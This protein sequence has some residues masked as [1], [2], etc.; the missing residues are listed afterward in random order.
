MEAMEQPEPASLAAGPTS[1][2]WPFDRVRDGQSA[3]LADARRTIAEGSHLLAHAPT[4]IGKTAVALVASLEYAM[5]AGKLV[6]FLTSRQSQHRIAIET[7]RRIEAKGPH[8]ATVDLIA[9]QSMCLQEG[10]PSFG[11]AFHEFCDLKVKSRSCAFFTR[12]NTAVVAAVLQRTFHVQELVRAS[13]A[14]RVCPHKVAMDAA[15]RAN[16]V[17]CDYNYVFSEILERF[18]PR[19]GRSLDELVL[20]VDE[21]HN[22]PD[23]IRAHLGGDLSVQDLL[24][25]AKEARSIDGEVAHQLVGVAKSIER[26]LLA[27]GSE[28]VARKEELV[29][30]VEAGLPKTLGRTFGY[31]DFVETLAFAGEAA[32]R[33]GVPS[34]L[35]VLAEFFARWR[36]HDDGILRLVV[37]G[38]EGKFAIR[39]M[40]PSLLS[41]RVFDAVH[42]SVLMSGTL[43]PAEMYADLLGI[44]AQ[45][46]VIRTY[47]SP[48]PR[49][50]RLLLVHPHL[51]TQYARRSEG[52]HD[53]IAREIAAIA[54]GAPG[55]VAAFF[56]S[57][58]QLGEAHRR[59]LGARLRKRLL[60]ERPEWTKAQRDG[61]LDVL[62]LARADGGALLLGVQGGSLS[63]GV[64]YESNL[65]TAVIVV[66]LPLSPPDVEVEALKDYYSRKFGSA[67]GYD[68]AYVFPAVNKVLQA[69]GRP[70]RSETDRAAIVL[71]EGRLLEPRYA[72][73]L[74]P[75]FSPVRSDSPASEVTGFLRSPPTSA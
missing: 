51:T 19:L 1:M 16:L 52:M 13:G 64:D 38:P 56:P 10:A 36:D 5:D 15:A 72:R 20:V 69:A 7:V 75:D 4:G 9:K 47:G 50:N 44:R 46:R 21:A 53:R 49:S 39:L 2:P 28:R 14:C 27:L 42:G 24:K 41:K 34:S 70:I 18:L 40:D 62:R 8:V 43:F 26:F 65:L 6:L 37:P 60:I 68:Y 11:R 67:K 30:A 12:D 58:E 74:P 48:F 25:G 35:P 63:E 29:D 23:R 33:R 3:F 31:A 55:N 32:S 59:I 57:Y 73:C 61:A 45:R 17:V 54:L 66:G 22:L 71:L